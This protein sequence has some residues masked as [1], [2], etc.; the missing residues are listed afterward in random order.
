MAVQQIS[1]VTLA[2]QDM[3]R[4]V[5]FYQARVGLG[6][7]YGGPTASFS[8]F[9]IGQGYLN[10]VLAPAGGWSWWG[11]FILHVDD[12]DRMFRRLLEAGLTPDHPP[13]DAPWGERYFHIT[14]PDGHEISFARRL[15][16]PSGN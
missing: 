6:L 11:R 2:V 15:E 8:S 12:V 3:A 16:N 10:L 14:D 4:A 7:L 9:R 1:A 13:Q 5:D